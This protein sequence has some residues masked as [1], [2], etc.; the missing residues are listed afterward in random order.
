MTVNIAN[1]RVELLP[2]KALFLH[3]HRV[4]M[5]ADLHL[6]KI[7]HFR[8][9]G[10]SVPLKA[11]EKNTE[12]LIELIQQTQPKRVVFLGDL[13]HS[14]YNEEWEVM[15]QITHHFKH[16]LFEL[17]LGNHD[18]LSLHQYERYRFQLH[19]Q[20]MVGNFVLTHEE[21]SEVPS[22]FYNLSG[23]VHPG[24]R[25]RGK[26]KQSIVLPCF[27]FRKRNG[28]LPAFGSFTG[29]FTVQ[30]KEGDKVFGVLTGK[31]MELTGG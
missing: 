14:H 10:I 21:L 30:P 20:L 6:G 24:I 22:N 12:L 28:L 23:H 3:H 31:V 17:V 16:I 18:I 1:E 8:K 7:N 13:F 19:Q 29:L 4:L 27:L 5:L 15:G 9:A 2:Q 26:G 11:N 25:L